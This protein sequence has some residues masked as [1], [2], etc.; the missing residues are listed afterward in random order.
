MKLRFLHLPCYNCERD[1]RW[2]DIRQQNAKKA[3]RDWTIY[4]HR[5]MHAR[6]QHFFWAQ[7]QIYAGMV[8]H[9][10][11][12]FYMLYIKP[13]MLKTWLSWFYRYYAQCFFFH[14]FLHFFTEK[15]WNFFLQNFYTSGVDFSNFSN[16]LS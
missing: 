12:M 1:G 6:N 11:F 9:N 16:F 8:H 4:S 2:K 5:R 7:N 3:T 10:Y 13:C 15:I 14:N